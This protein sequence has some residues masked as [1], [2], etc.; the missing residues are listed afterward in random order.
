LRATVSEL[1]DTLNV[2]SAIDCVNVAEV[3]PAK[4][5]FVEANAATTVWVPALSELV[6]N[7]ADPLD[8]PTVADVAQRRNERNRGQPLSMSCTAV[9]P[10]GLLLPG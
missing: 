8:S 1:G 7:C 4:F 10:G 3:L 6:E 5:A 9:Q 2:K